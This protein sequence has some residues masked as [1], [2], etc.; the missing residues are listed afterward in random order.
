MNEDMSPLL[1][2]V[3]GPTLC[4]TDLR[5]LCAC[6]LSLWVHM[7]VDP[8][9]LESLDSLVSSIPSGSYTLNCLLFTKVS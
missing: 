8:V 3:L 6:C 9:D 5:R 2:L 4:G 7:Q 1:L